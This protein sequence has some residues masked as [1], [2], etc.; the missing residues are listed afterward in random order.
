[1]HAV[2]AEAELWRVLNAT[3]LDADFLAAG[4]AA[5]VADHEAADRV[6]RDRLSAVD[7]ELAKQRR[8]LDNQTDQLADAGSGELRA[9]ILRRAKEIEVLIARLAA[10]RADLAAVRGE[11]LS[12]DEADAIR[13]FADRAREGLALATP[14][15][16]RDLYETLDLRGT[17]RLATADDA[18]AVRLGR[19]YRFRI[20][21]TGRIPLVN[22]AGRLFTKPIT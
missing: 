7:A 8:R 15:D 11:G 18:D 10:E 16:R 6:R 12:P 14:A 21:W 17:V 4:L 5:G 2:H 13:T 9:S 20:D 3:L 1:V 22:S 19:K